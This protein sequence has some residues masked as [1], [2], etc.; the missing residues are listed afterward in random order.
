MSESHVVCPGCQA[1]FR[2][3]EGFSKESVPCKKCGATIVIPAPEA[4]ATP[5]PAAPVRRGALD[6]ARSAAPAGRRPRGRRGDAA[7]AARSRRGR[8]A[9]ETG[10]K[11]A[12]KK[13][14]LI[15][16]ASALGV[17][18]VGLVIFLV[19]RSGGEDA[20]SPAATDPGST[21]ASPANS[22]NEPLEPEPTPTPVPSA[23]SKA[24]PAAAGDSQERGG[25]ALFAE[26]PGK[27]ARYEVE[28]LPHLDDTSSDT[29]E[30]IDSNIVKLV[31]VSNPRI[32]N[33]A[34]RE[35]VGIGRPAIPRL[36]SAWVDLRMDDERDVMAGN[37]L[38]QTLGEITGK[39][40]VYSPEQ[41]TSPSD[42]K[43]R[44][45]VLS[46]WFTWWGQNKDTFR[47]RSDSD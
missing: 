9:E 1:R 3:P 36:L 4:G 31:D 40:I 30:R 34:R 47:E 45:K 39:E 32:G 14:G 27:K 38:H 15:V 28:K 44:E 10:E 23:S 17:A 19:V 35:L 29:R 46:S 13:T 25:D 42:A 20:P 24:A 18:L 43:L 11:K 12:S 7:P 6:R 8:G 41:P 21:A 22:A 33:D 2:I 37:M 16:T 5:P 26:K